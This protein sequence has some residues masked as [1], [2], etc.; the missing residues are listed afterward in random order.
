MPLLR[1][2][3]RIKSQVYSL[4]NQPFRCKFQQVFQRNRIILS[5]SNVMSFWFLM[6]TIAFTLD[7]AKLMPI[8]FFNSILR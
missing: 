5:F 3:C 1:L 6:L 2:M 8:C 7:N 4:K